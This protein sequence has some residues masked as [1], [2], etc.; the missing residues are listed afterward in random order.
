MKEML[1]AVLAISIASTSCS[2]IGAQE[3]IEPIPEQEESAPSPSLE[4]TEFVHMKFNPT[5]PYQYD[6]LYGKIEHRG[7]VILLDTSR[8]FTKQW[9]DSLDTGITLLEQTHSEER[10]ENIRKN[11]II[12]FDKANALPAGVNLNVVQDF[13]VEERRLICVLSI[14][15]PLMASKFVHEAG[16]VYWWLHI[17]YRE[18]EESKALYEKNKNLWIGEYAA[19][20]YKEYFAE[21][22]RL[23][24]ID[25]KYLLNR[26]PEG[27][28]LMA[29]LPE[30]WRDTS[31][32]R[33][34]IDPDA[35]LEEI[36]SQYPEDILC[37]GGHKH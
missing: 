28:D 30:W 33:I 35:L 12:L 11:T 14:R 4:I 18:L 13:P 29:S 10:Y 2:I 24:H 27:H 7:W 6:G 19:K 15:I 9:M 3:E 32:G 17:G 16:H 36:R 25:P 8:V 20:N 21:K 1:I 5:V 22:Y 37:E 26:D 34:I 31:G 23:Y